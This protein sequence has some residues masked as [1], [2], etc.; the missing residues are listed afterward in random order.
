MDEYKETLS[1]LKFICKLKRGDKINISRMI[2]Q[3]N[4]ILTTISRTIFNQDNRKNTLTFINQ[5]VTKSFEILKKLKTS[6]HIYSISMSDHLIKDLINAKE[7]M[8][9]LKFIWTLSFR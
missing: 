7:G 5:T 3:P 4:S 9:C 2:V 6:N 1:N 8:N